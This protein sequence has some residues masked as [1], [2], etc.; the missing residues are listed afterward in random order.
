MYIMGDKLKLPKS[1]VEMARI[2]VCDICLHVEKSANPLPAIVDGPTVNG[3]WGY[4]C[5]Q[6]YQTYATHGAQAMG[7]HLVV[8]GGK[9]S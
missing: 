2:P 5:E 4:M 8:I 3:A 1:Q 7:S 6:H 9:T